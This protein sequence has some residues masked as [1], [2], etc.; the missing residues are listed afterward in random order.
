MLQERKKRYSEFDEGEGLLNVI[1]WRRCTIYS[2][3]AV[4]FRVGPVKEQF[5]KEDTGGGASTNR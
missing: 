1:V 4:F 2:W 3:R 5:A